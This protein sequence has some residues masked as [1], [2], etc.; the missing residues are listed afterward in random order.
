M[1]SKIPSYRYKCESFHYEKSTIIKPQ[2]WM[3]PLNEKVSTKGL[4][5]EF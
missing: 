5:T 2:E 3:M 1:S 4:G